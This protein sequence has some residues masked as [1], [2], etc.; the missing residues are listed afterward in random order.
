MSND[1]LQN[2]VDNMILE[3]QR[4]REDDCKLNLKNLIEELEKLPKELKK[5]KVMIDMNGFYDIKVYATGIDSYRGYYSDLAIE[6]S[7]NKKDGLT[8]N[9]LIKKLK[10]AIGKTFIGYKGG[11]FVM[12]EGTVVWL[13]NYG[14][15]TGRQITGI[16]NFY[17]EI[18]LQNEKVED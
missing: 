10:Q 15:S 5:N 1:Y 3:L 7:L 13:G 14:K 6:Y 9:Q 11:E 12:H 18:F 8:V 16:D 17:G 2:Y 4:K